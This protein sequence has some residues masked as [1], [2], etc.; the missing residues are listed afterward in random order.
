MEKFDVALVGATGAVGEMM[1]TVL[2]Q[3]DF[4]VQQL[5]PLASQR[6]VGRTVVFRE[7]TL[8]VEVLEN[9][10]FSK[11]DIALFS[12][13]ASVSDIY[14]PRAASAGN[15]VIDNTSRFRNE[16]DIPLIV[17]E[18]NPHAAAQYSKRRIIANPN[19]STIQMVVVL[20]PLHD[21]FRISRVNVATYQAVSGAGRRAVAELLDQTHAALDG[22]AVAGDIYP[23]Q[24]AFNAIP[25]IDVFLDNG[26]T[27]E[28]MKMVWETQKILD[29]KT[30]Q[31]NPT[32]VRVPVINGHSEAVHLEFFNEV[33]EGVARQALQQAP[34]VVVL[35]EHRAG[36][37]PTAATDASGHD[38]VF[39]GRIRRD[40]SHPT[41]LNLWVVSDNLRKGAATNSVQ[42]AELIIRDYLQS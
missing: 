42:I 7:R 22:Q 28:E 26:Y 33:D 21:L 17:P 18:V 40:I 2:E 19:C 24:I 35:D 8:A 41:G 9:F 31:I 34:G 16:A 4:P 10:D 15:I 37:Y 27:K 5:Y 1:L 23:K 25:Q 30:I 39:V 36:A 32:T 29:D 38:E 13:G 12:A 3:R 20:K 11:T 6:S 14:A